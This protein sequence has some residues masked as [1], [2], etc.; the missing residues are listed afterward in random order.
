MAVAMEIKTT[1]FSVISFTKFKWEY[2]S[3]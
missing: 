3:C 2:F 1:L